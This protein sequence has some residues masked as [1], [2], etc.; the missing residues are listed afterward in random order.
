MQ[1]RTLKSADPRQGPNALRAFCK[2][3]R[4]RPLQQHAG[5]TWTYAH[6]QLWIQHIDGAIYAVVDARGGLAIDG[7]AF[8]Q[9]AEGAAQ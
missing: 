6:G 7:F 3:G 4:M 9:V 5:W 1:H 8:E 2:Q